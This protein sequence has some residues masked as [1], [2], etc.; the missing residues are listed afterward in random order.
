MPQEPAGG[1]G[2][3]YMVRDVGILT[4]EGHDTVKSQLSEPTLCW[5]MSGRRRTD[6]VLNGPLRRAS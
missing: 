3:S 1:H 4:L 6:W 5:G 2:K